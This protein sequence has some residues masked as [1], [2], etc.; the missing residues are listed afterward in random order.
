[1]HDDSITES[2]GQVKTGGKDM[3]NRKQS[4]DVMTNSDGFSGDDSD[5]DSSD[6]DGTMKSKLQK[7]QTTVTAKGKTSLNSILENENFNFKLSELVACEFKIRED[8]SDFDLSHEQL[9]KVMKIFMYKM[10]LINK[11]S[12]Y[13]KV[14]F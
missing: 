4:R 8:D 7:K 14:E 10:N 11:K 6:E 3:N 12:Q 5:D 13:E 9:I 2:L 1:M